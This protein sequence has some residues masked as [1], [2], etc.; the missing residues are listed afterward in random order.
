MVINTHIEQGLTLGTTV[1]EDGLGQALQGCFSSRATRQFF[2]AREALSA[3][4]RI[5]VEPFLGPASNFR[6]G[7]TPGVQRGRVLGI[8]GTGEIGRTVA[9]EA[10]A[11][12]GCEVLHY[13]AK[14]L[15][16]DLELVAKPV[17]LSTLFSTADVVVLVLPTDSETSDWIGRRESEL[18]SPER[19]FVARRR[20]RGI[21]SALAFL[22]Q[23]YAERIFIGDLAAKAGLSEFHFQ[24]RFNAMLGITPHRYQ[25]MLRVFHAKSVL[26]RGMPI[27]DVATSVGFADQSHL[28]RYFRRIVGVTP[29]QYQKRFVA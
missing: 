22:S 14:P 23:N 12:L 10:R 15:G 20:A 16:L 9:R 17:D 5:C 7:G 27:R 25:L 3:P 2:Q 6:A 8:L 4:D 26:R 13:C 18:L 24:H 28:H 1:M 11:R 29:G 19:L 21:E